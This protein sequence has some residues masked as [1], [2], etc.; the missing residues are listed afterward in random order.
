MHRLWCSGI[1]LSVVNMS[2]AMTFEA[3]EMDTS[4]LACILPYLDHYLY[5][6]RTLLLPRARCFIATSCFMYEQDMNKINFDLYIAGHVFKWY[7]YAENVTRVL[8]TVNYFIVR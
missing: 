7:Q 8:H 4:Y 2:K 5:F 1:F 6:L 3:Y